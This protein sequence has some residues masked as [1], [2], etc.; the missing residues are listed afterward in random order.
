MK[1][2][3]RNIAP[4]AAAMV[5]LGLAALHGGGPAAHAQALQA[6]PQVVF[7]VGNSESMDGTLSGAIMTGSGM[8]AGSGNL[9]SLTSSS[10][11]V[12]YTVPP[13]FTPPKQGAD[14]WGKAPYTF[15]GGGMLYDNGAS[16]LNVAKAGIAST[17]Q[18]YLGSMD[19]ALATYQ[20]SGS[21]LYTTWA[22]YMSPL[23]GF[24]FTN[25]PVAG[26]RYVNNPCYSTSGAAGLSAGV[27]NNCQAIAAANLYDAAAA[28]GGIYANRLMEIA[29]SAD[30][31]NINDVL[32]A[33]GLNALWVSYGTV[34]TGNNVVVTPP[35]ANTPYT[36]YG[37]N[38]YNNGGVF[39]GYSHS[40]PRG[41]SGTSPTNAGYV[42]F[43]S[44]VMF[45]Q[46]GFGYGGSQSATTGKTVVSMTSL[47]SSPTDAAIAT[48]F[49]QFK[50]L[51]DPETN[52][53][54]TGEIK[55]IAGQAATAGLVVGAGNVLRDLAANCAGQYVILVTDG[56]P[57]LDMNNKAWPPLGSESGLGYGVYATF[58]GQPA[59]PFYGLRDGTG[60][61]LPLGSLVEGSAQTNDQA[62]IDTIAQI[63]ALKA[64]GIK[65]YVIGLGAGVDATQNPAANAALNAMAIAGGTGQQYPANDIPAFQA[66]LS[67][68]AAQIYASTQ[69]T[70]PVAPGSVTSGSK[71]YVVT[72]KNQSGAMG[73]H[74]EA[75]NT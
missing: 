23:G 21:S 67:A 43:S 15:S 40:T 9:D 19:F 37:L 49:N 59:N 26:R 46:R 33:G 30:D 14:A 55:A 61:S 29:S 38:N 50:P 51:L 66:A 31:A 2:P 45:V 72:S 7:A 74:V 60:S 8:F 34:K 70:A 5:G 44:Q 52:R 69:I 68:I 16:R 71:V 18:S 47:G 41:V 57:T 11:P 63:A 20:T 28:P 73:G 1:H 36:A 75:Y 3:H 54:H 10:S 13:G 65:T 53:I 48:A 64:R 39:V 42:P 35:N 24:R 6:R 25:T 12:H 62:L 27:R 22:Y 56:L 4:I 17:L 32:Y 58:A